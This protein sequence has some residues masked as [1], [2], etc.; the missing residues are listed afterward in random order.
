[1][2]ANILNKR[3]RALLWRPTEPVHLSGD[4]Q[5]SCTSLENL[6]TSQIVHRNPFH[7]VVEISFK[8]R[9]RTFSSNQQFSMPTRIV[10]PSQLSRI[11]AARGPLFC[12]RLKFSAKS[13]TI[14]VS[15]IF[16]GFSLQ[17]YRVFVSKK[18]LKTFLHSEN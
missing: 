13:K 15:L 3:T 9:S 4:Q 6:W 11:F 17:I 18:N 8:A 12:S 2:P 5:N 16:D 14:V 7:N 10:T 1:M